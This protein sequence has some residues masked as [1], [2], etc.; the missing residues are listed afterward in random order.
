VRE[1][2][3]LKIKN[4]KIF[5]RQVKN[6][7]ILNFANEKNIKYFE[8]SAKIGGESLQKFY[9]ALTEILYQKLIVKDH[10]NKL[11]QSLRKI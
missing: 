1:S 4:Q 7:I 8:T 5:K 9:E 11:D 6:D 10:S 3:G 2:N